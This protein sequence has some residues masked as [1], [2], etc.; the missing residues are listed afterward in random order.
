MRVIG[1]GQ[2]LAGDDGVGLV[3]AARI[4]ER[5]GASIEVIEIGDATAL[6]EALVSPGRV[7]IVD[8]V[9]GGGQPGTIHVV[10]PEVLAGERLA[11]VSTH[12]IDVLQAI[13]MA[14]ILYPDAVSTDVHIV[15]IEIEKAEPTGEGLSPAVAG[16]VDYAVGV[17]L[18][19]RV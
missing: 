2:R 5:A 9:I 12:G 18:G 10:S 3:V 13:E 15:G 11:A 19:L 14:R 17:V 1:L 7:V 8:A 16:A 4:A 6:I